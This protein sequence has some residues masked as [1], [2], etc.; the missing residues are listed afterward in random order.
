M[1]IK[2]LRITIIAILSIVIGFGLASAT[3]FDNFKVAGLWGLIAFITIV[4][5]IFDVIYKKRNSKLPGIA[6][7]IL[8]IAFIVSIPIRKH[9]WNKQTKT[10]EIVINQLDTYNKQ[11]GNYPD[12]LN[13]LK[14]GIDLSEINYSTDSLKQTFYISYSVDG[15][16]TERYDSK[17]REWTGG[18]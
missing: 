12:S 13:S 8:T 2:K 6:L 11:N 18:D 4:I 1:Q 15:W 14:L 5:G 9:Y 3:I 16:H 7:T 10:C 17:N